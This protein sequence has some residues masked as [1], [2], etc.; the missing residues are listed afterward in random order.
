M[1]KG[2]VRRRFA[3]FSHFP[4]P[5]HCTVSAY[6]PSDGQYRD[7][8]HRQN[9]ET[10]RQVERHATPPPRIEK[11]WAETTQRLLTAIRLPAR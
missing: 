11:S 3:G 9:K 5:L 8:D 4:R 10:E 6:S 2:P 1:S 7:R